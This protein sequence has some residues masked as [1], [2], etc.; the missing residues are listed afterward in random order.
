[1]FVGDQTLSTLLRVSIEKV[2]DVEQGSVTLFAR[3]LVSGVMRPC[4]LPDGSLLLGQTGRGWG[5]SGG[6]E[7]GLQRIVFDPKVLPADIHH[8]SSAKSGFTVHFTQPL[9]SSLTGADLAGK[10]NVRSW[11]YLDSV[12]YGSPELEQRDDKIET[13]DLSTDRKSATITLTGFGQGDKWLDRIYAIKIN[14][15]KQLFPE[16]SAWDELESFFTLRAIPK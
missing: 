12:Q 8:V 15:T 16:A 4:F 14:Q 3:G 11:F 2:G 6:K 1:M 7:D 10:I 5:A 9:A 13:I